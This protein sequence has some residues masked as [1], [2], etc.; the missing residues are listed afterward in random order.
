MSN[1]VHLRVLNATN[2]EVKCTDI[3]GGSFENLKV[4]DVIAS[5]DMGV[6]ASADNSRIYCKFEA[7]SLG[8]K[9]YWE[10]GMTNPKMSGNA[11]QGSDNA[12]LQPYGSDGNFTYVLGFKNAADW[13]NR[14][15]DK[16]VRVD[17]GS[18]P[19]I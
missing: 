2:G 19:L 15:E 6:Y 8:S 17:Y 12:G 16:G 18:Q 9:I 4:G 11:A 1:R 3:R 5:R 7:E 10:L 14:S 13:E